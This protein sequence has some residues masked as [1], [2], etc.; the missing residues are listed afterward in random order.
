MFVNILMHSI[1]KDIVIQCRWIV[2]L[3]FGCNGTGGMMFNGLTTATRR[4]AFAAVPLIKSK[5]LS[6]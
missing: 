5:N 3:H 6:L 1:D 2:G 4:M